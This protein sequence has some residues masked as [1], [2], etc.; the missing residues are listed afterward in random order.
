MQPNETVWHLKTFSIR[1]LALVTILVWTALAVITT[2]WECNDNEEFKRS[3]ALTTSRACIEK[4]LAFRRWAAGHGGVYVPVTGTTPP[5]P[6]LNVPERDI[7]TPSGTRLTLMNPAYM[8]RQLFEVGQTSASAPKGHI[9]SLKP[10]RPENAPDQWE[11]RA[12]MAFE[13]GVPEFGEFLFVDGKPA[14]RYM[15]PLFIEKPCL[16]C[17]ASHGY[18]EGM[19][20]GGISV[21]IP[22]AG[23]EQATRQSNANHVAIIGVIW[24]MGLAG[25]GAAFRRIGT[26]ATALTAERDNLNAVFDAT[27]MPMLL[28]DDRMEVVRV[29]AA[30]RDYC[31]DFDVLPDRRCG[32]LLKCAN[33]PSELHGCGTTP[34]CDSCGLMRALRE[35]AVNGLSSRGETCVSRTGAEGA[36]TEVW[37]IYGTEAVSLAGRNH[38][39]LSFTDITERKQD[40]AQRRVRAEEFRAL[41]EN[42]PDPIAR[43]D[44]HCRRIY[45]NP[46]L[47]HLAGKPAEFLTGRTPAEAFV[48]NP[49][50]GH[51]VQEAVEQVLNHGVSLEIEMSWPSSDG[52][53][54]HYQVRFVPEFDENRKV[55][56]VLSITRD[57]TS[58]RKAEV[59]LQHAQK[60]ESIGTLAG[61][62]AHDFNNILS[63]IGGYAELLQLTLKEDGKKFGFA[64]EI[65]DSVV[66]GA[67]LTRSLLTFSGKHEPQKQ[68]DDL[69]QIV[70]NLQKSMS[71]LLRS[72]ITLTFRLCEDPLPVFV[73]R[74][75]IEQVLI[76][77]MVN[78]RDALTSDGQIDI[79]TSLV[80]L[81]EE[82]VTG[83]ATLSPGTYGYVT[84]ADNGTGMDEKTAKRIFEPFFTTK[85]TGKGTGLGLAIAFGIVGNH[86]G[87]ISI[88]S[89]PEK[90]SVFGV[91]LP[92]YQGLTAPKSVPEAGTAKFHG[93]E[94]VLLVDDDPTVLRITRELLE[95]YGYSVLTAADGMAALK[96]FEAHRTEIR[97]VVTDLIMP[98]M[99]GRE[100]IEQIRHQKPDLPIILTSGYMDDIIDHT[101][102]NAL[103]VVFLPKPV[104]PK[105]LAETIR[106][107][108]AGCRDAGITE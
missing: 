58:L 31:I 3:N 6:W 83:G 68:Y 47:E 27:P 96:V 75:Q 92:I 35:T 23:L 101:A 59:Q 38:V 105:K 48:A 39:V 17:H 80:E 74:V 5:N 1:R 62:V 21:I 30:F 66:R 43:Y 78:A 94:T 76:N 91:Y 63:V 70:G 107:G 55:T 32:A 11:S 8:T 53:A 57:I 89:A 56:S 88:E 46:A 24:L 82:V 87:R 93:D 36:A 81:H 50:V 54:R 41:V 65:S 15:R 37:L 44:S 64:R 22:T 34:A 86:H 18:R 14:Y 20:R 25:I 108:L 2:I 95:S 77:L 72:D 103:G 49:A 73:D 26:Y 67:E 90:G 100:A 60:M 40:E 45:V 106:A 79:T 71:R 7:T 99:A 42:S 61:G 29:N 9:T 19:V 4:D 98:H 13:T 69:N 102:I 12:L 84:V 28:I 85:E 33:V 52:T 51:Q 16:K 104:H 97:I 10:I